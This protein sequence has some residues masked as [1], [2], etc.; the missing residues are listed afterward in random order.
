MSDETLPVIVVATQNA[1]KVRE[2]AVLLADLPARFVTARE[3]G[4]LVLPEETGTTF[5]ENAAIKAR[6]V[7]AATGLPALADDSGLVVDA[8]DGAPGVFS[9]RYG[10]AGLTDRDRHTLVLNQLRDAAPAG[11]TARFVAV[12]ALVLP[13][14]GMHQAEGTVEGAI[15]DAPRGSGGFGYDPI[16]V[17]HGEDSTFAEI[18]ADQKN[19]M[20]HRARAL[21]ALRPALERVV[22]NRSQ[23]R[24][25]HCPCT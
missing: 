25:A 4:V 12:L 3:A 21:A 9:A 10:G 8:L 24:N 18:P 19:R 11:R 6:A 1:G 13:D 5:A 17:P 20:S 15:A 7:A 16:F 14:G 22:R 2:F 23:G